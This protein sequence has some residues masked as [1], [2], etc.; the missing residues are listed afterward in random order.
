MGSL[1]LTGGVLAA[2]LQP[3]LPPPPR[4]L[5][6]QRRARSRLPFSPGTQLASFLM[7]A[8]SDLL[9]LATEF[10]SPR[11]SITLVLKR[12]AGGRRRAPSFA[13]D[14]MVW[15]DKVR[16]HTRCHVWWLQ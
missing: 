13:H 4:A 11:R 2:L 6:L 12:R 14:G 7:G 5:L 16:T 15:R 10:M 9:T 1:V 3:P 8:L